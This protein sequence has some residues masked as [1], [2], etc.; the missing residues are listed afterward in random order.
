MSKHARIEAKIRRILQHKPSAST[1]HIKQR[2]FTFGVNART[3]HAHLMPFYRQH[4]IDD[5]LHIQ[6][7]FA[8]LMK[9][10]KG[11]ALIAS[12]LRRTPYNPFQ[13]EAFLDERFADFDHLAQAKL[14][15]AL[16]FGKTPPQT[17]DERSKQLF[18]LQKQ[19]HS[20]PV[21]RNVLRDEKSPRFIYPR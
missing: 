11:F 3:L 14:S 1:L 6:R 21:V 13:V 9:E 7:H 18:Y 5:R 4:H 17:V 19:G 10:G 2:L 8:H 20:L 15:Q 16:R 12:A